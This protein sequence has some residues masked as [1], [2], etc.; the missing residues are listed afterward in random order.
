MMNP[1]CREWSR[2]RNNMKGDVSGYRV[3]SDLWIRHHVDECLSLPFLVSV[4]YTKKHRDGNGPINLYEV[5]DG[6]VRSL[7]P[8]C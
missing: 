4:G 2:I 3:G 8:E 6:A 7:Q 5:D 1:Q